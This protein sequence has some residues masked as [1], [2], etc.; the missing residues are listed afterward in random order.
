[1]TPLE[2]ERVR[3]EVFSR[4]GECV[5][6]RK[7]DAGRCGGKL[8]FHHRR[9]AG[10]GGAYCVD[11]GATLCVFHNDLIEDEPG[12]FVGDG[13]LARHRL[14]IREGDPEWEKLGRRYQREKNR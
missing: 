6:A 9:K 12:W 14:V 4:D 13:K 10:A 2:K 5:L 3:Q 8:T 7:H 1:V 11:N